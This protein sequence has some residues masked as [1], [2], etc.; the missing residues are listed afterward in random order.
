M[1]V[2]LNSCSSRL[3]YFDRPGLQLE[4]RWAVKAVGAGRP[5][6]T[7]ACH[8]TYSVS[9]WINQRTKMRY[10]KSGKD[11]FQ[12]LPKVRSLSYI[13]VIYIT[14]RLTLFGMTE[15]SLLWYLNFNR[16]RWNEPYM[17]NTFLL[18]PACLVIS[19]SYCYARRRG[20]DSHSGQIFL[21]FLCL[22]EI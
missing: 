12:R 14:Q 6:I 10:K 19:D 11:G 13:P 15:N 1:S 7:T 17:P 4:C 8:F 16:I 9:F 18:I 20:F 21:G 2:C 5:A 3:V 22:L